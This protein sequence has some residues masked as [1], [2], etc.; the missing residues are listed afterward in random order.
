VT[1]KR[2]RT[3]SQGTARGKAPAA[4]RA[5]EPKAAAVPED[6]PAPLRAIKGASRKAEA[7]PENDEVERISQADMDYL[8]QVRNQLHE[9][10]QID[11]QIEQMLARKLTLAGAYDNYCQ[12]LSTR[13]GL[14][15]ERDQ[16]MDDG[17]IKR[18]APARA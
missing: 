14:D 6:V 13:Y 1:E 3:R 18:A 12:F 16:V 10:Q 7:A 5:V 9:I 11:A 17:V 8:L 2:A 15:L 4:L